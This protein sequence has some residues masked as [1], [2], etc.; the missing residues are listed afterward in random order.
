V[1]FVTAAVPRVTHVFKTKGSWWNDAF[2][3]T[4]DEFTCALDEAREPCP[5]SCA[6]LNSIRAA[7][8]MLRS[9]ENGEAALL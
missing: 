5:S 8:A 1:K 6:N 3:G 2:G 4:M 9:S 7:P